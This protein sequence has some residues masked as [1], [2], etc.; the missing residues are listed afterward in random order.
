M[1]YQQFVEQ[2]CTQI[3][4]MSGN[5]IIA[6]VHTA[7]KNNSVMR[8]GITLINSEINISP[9]LYLEELYEEFLDG[10]PLLDIVF[11][12]LEIY[13]EIR[14]EHSW[15]I[16]ELL[17]YDAISNK[18]AYKLIHF[19]RNLPFLE[20]VPYIRYHDLAI[21]FFLLIE[22]NPCGNGTILITNE[23]LTSWKITP[24]DL[25]QTAAVNT[26]KLFPSVFKP[27]CAVVSE[28][29]GTVCTYED[30]MD[31]RMYILTNSIK[32]FGSATILY[33]NTL[34]DIANELQD[35]F[36]LIPS[37]IH[38]III[39]PRRYSPSAPEL[40]QMI[41]EVNQTELSE[42]EVLSDHAYYYSR[43]HKSVLWTH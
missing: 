28:M 6:E 27:M 41:K 21:V 42:D 38:E 22:V 8:T 37:S 16:G 14:F 26:P 3:N 15:N 7:L 32:H 18:I 25:Y 4:D 24:E 10:C 12:I 2:V 19:K 1:T 34:E 43:L 5:S 13:D 35:D 9:T 40:D 23:M 31:N 11:R 29:L 30:M 36:Y 20:T 17:N 33:K 39:L